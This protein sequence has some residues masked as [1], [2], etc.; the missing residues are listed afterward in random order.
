M[1]LLTMIGAIGQF[2]KEMMLERQ[3]E[4]IAK[5][6]SEGKYKGRAPTARVK[7][8]EVRA[9]HAQR[10]GATEIANRLAI[11]RASVYRILTSGQ[12]PLQRDSSS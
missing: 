3:R 6:K 8:D 10:V 4:G 11:G 12:R 2:E 1:F 5:A 9:L 7:A